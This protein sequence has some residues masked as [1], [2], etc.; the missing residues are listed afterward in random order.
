[1]FFSPSK[2]ETPYFFLYFMEQPETA[3]QKPEK[4]L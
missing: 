1:M 4:F 3:N 2:S